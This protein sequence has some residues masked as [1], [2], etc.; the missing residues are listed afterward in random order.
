MVDLYILYGFS[1]IRTYIS[2]MD[3][4]GHGNVSI[5]THQVLMDR[6]QHMMALLRELRET[7]VKESSWNTSDEAR[8]TR[9][10]ILLM[11]EILANQ[12]ISW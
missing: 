12:L 3:P 9:K 8:G 2:F 7:F 6:V 4:M 1:C 10:G 5:R 11:A